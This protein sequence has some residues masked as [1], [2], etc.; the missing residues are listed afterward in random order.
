M[1][2]IEPTTTEP[3][4]PTADPDPML[5]A[6][7][8]ADSAQRAYAAAEAADSRA[9]LISERAER[10]KLWWTLWG[11]GVGLFCGV[12]AIM[13]ISKPFARAEVYDE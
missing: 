4:Q 13:L 12:M 3:A 6:Q 1:K 11:A 5:V 2:A 7:A 10:D 8:C 9:E